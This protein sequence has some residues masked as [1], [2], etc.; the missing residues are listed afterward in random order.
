[1]R[2]D[3]LLSFVLL[4]APALAEV[5]AVVADTPVTASLVQQVMGDLGQPVL[6]LDKGA[7]PHD[8]QLRPS[9]ARALQGA[10]LLIW[11]G[12]ELT[13]WLDRAATRIAPQK[14]LPL[15]PAS[16]V[17]RSY[18]TDAAQE[19][20]THT[21]ADHDHNGLDPH[22]W[23]DPQNGAAWLDAIA[24]RLSEAD[25]EHTPAYRANAT[26]A[27]TALADRDAALTQLLTP[28]KGR[29]FVTFHDAY[30]YFTDHYGLAPGIAVTLGDA[31]APSAARIR[32]VQD[33][34]IAAG[35]VCA[36]PEANQPN[37]LIE[38]LTAGTD[39]RIGEPLSPEGTELDAGAGLYGQLLDQLGQRLTACLT[40]PSQ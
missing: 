40:A 35:A 13:P 29:A 9:Q 25:P 16:P 30:G 11:V 3:F 8:F 17:R 21:S 24:A 28:A 32:E 20:D 31:S 18:G 15:L 1:M 5:P 23:L 10:D 33:Q 38:D 19:Q 26:A 34:I 37:R 14:Q 12:P 6:L 7:D 22:A 39:L 27:R 36:F 4:G 2:P